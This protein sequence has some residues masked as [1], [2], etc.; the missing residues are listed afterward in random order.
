MENYH[1]AS[2]EHQNNPLETIFQN[3]SG[4][5][6]SNITHNESQQT[7]K[8]HNFQTNPLTNN[9]VAGNHNHQMPPSYQYGLISQNNNS[10]S[11]QVQ[12]LTSQS[13]LLNFD[14][15]SM[16]D[17]TKNQL[18][19]QFDIAVNQNGIFQAPKGS[20]DD[21]V[22]S[23]QSSEMNS[24]QISGGSEQHHQTYQ[25]F[26][27]Q[28]IKQLLQQSNQNM[29]SLP[30]LNISTQLQSQP[31]NFENTQ[32]S[33]ADQ[34]IE[35]SKKRIQ[36]ISE[37]M[38]PPSEVMNTY[39]KKD[40]QSQN[41]QFDDNV[42]FKPQQFE[43]LKPDLQN[44]YSLKT[45]NMQ[46]STKV[47]EN[48]LK[49]LQDKILD[50]ENKLCVT[51]TTAFSYNN[52]NQGYMYSLNKIKPKRPETESQDANKRK[53]KVDIDLNNL[54][55]RVEQDSDFISLQNTKTKKLMKD[56]FSPQ[57]Q[58]SINSTKNNNKNLQ[59]RIQ[60]KTRSESKDPKS[61]RNFTPQRG[62]T[63]DTIQSNK[64][65]T[66]ASTNRSKL[67]NQSKSKLNIT[68]QSNISSRVGKDLLSQREVSR[69]QNQS[70]SNLGN[71]KQQ[72]QRALS[73]PQ[74]AQQK[75]KP[76]ANNRLNQSRDTTLMDITN[77]QNQKRQN[78]Q[79]ESVQSNYK[80]IAS[81]VVELQ[82]QIMS[83]RGKLKMKEGV[84][85]ENDKLREE[86]NEMR[87]KFMDSEK[88]KQKYKEQVE[89]LQVANDR[90]TKENKGLK[91]E[92]GELVMGS[93]K[94]KAI[95]K[96]KKTK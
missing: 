90:L 30:D 6:V 95:T 42:Q 16:F 65:N 22:I 80:E 94:N 27:S 62:F 50:L 31:N 37:L 44:D 46:K 8:M 19:D 13:N 88:R 72:Q 79:E 33:V 78:N 49:T 66:S 58:F 71:I 21:S 61:K 11:G 75:P 35:Q 29:F 32:K 18:S 85:T 91:E 23:S 7:L 73:R 4:S 52:S 36:D 26:K 86:L 63:K 45:Q 77:T 3:R 87:Q 47:M 51:S 76:I 74:T 2:Q 56:Q 25:Q 20:L 68:G 53:I 83:L 82:R 40:Y 93:K 14:Y 17:S 57:S 84:E 15:S 48:E 89:D 59:Q 39:L 41:L 38:K 81:K 5:M 43:L 64:L 67:R 34:L 10:N 96:A 69:G 70:S 92:I 24:N 60:S 12:E 9:Q 55:S 1:L 28:G 54:S